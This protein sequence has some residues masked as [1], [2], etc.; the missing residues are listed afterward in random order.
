ML[1]QSPLVE[2]GESQESPL[3]ELGEIQES[4][5]IIERNRSSLVP[6]VKLTEIISFRLVVIEIVYTVKVDLVPTEH[7]SLEIRAIISTLWGY[8][9]L[10]GLL[11][12][13]NL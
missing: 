11:H 7:V 3:V 2:L 5:L 1:E 12:Q 4:G 8:V 10:K 9:F 6:Q 13:K